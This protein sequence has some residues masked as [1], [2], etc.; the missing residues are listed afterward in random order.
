MLFRVPAM[1]GLSL[2]GPIRTQEGG[3]G[4]DSKSTSTKT[5][6]SNL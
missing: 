5:E 4:L 1:L 6:V 2:L 3:G